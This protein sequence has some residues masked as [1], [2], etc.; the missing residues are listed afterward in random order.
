MLI[1]FIL[2]F[3]IFSQRI[4]NVQSQYYILFATLMIVL[5]MSFI[6]FSVVAT[7]TKLVDNVFFNFINSIFDNPSS[8]NFLSIISLILFVILVY[9]L[10]EYDNNKPHYALDKLMM[11]RN[12]YIS[13]RAGGIIVIFTF[14]LLVSYTVMTTTKQ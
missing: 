1:F 11:G 5:I 6:I 13:N 14:S 10:V 2:I 7:D 9:E 4:F 12:N 8:R 3:L